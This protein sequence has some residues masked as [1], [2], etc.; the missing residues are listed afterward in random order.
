M[1]THA[2][3]INLPF[4]INYQ[5]DK[6]KGKKL[7]ILLHGFAQSAEYMKQ[8]FHNLIPEDFDILI[9]NGPFPIPK[10]RRD[11]IEKRYAWYFFDRH[12]GKYDIDYS[13]PSNLLKEL[14]SSLGYANTSKTIIGY[15][16]GGYLS[17]FAALELNQVESIIGIGCTYK[18][19]FLP[20]ELP[21][22]IYSIHGKKDQIVEIDNSREHFEELKKRTKLQSS[23][24]CLENSA[25][26]LDADM[27]NEALK[28]L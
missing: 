2:L 21:Y 25:H 8:Y 16:Q 23:Y 18:W 10:I 20:D 19:Q 7:L 3:K 27:V 14:V 9:P 15:S 4:P 5:L 24:I 13:F 6:R 12:T 26:E 11:Y 28:L 22:N 1:K 17:P